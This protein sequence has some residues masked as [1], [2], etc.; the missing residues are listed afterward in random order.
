[1]RIFAVLRPDDTVAIDVRPDDSAPNLPYVENP[2]V[3]EGHEIIGIE[4][5]ALVTQEIDTLAVERSAM[6]CSPVQMRLACLGA[7]MLAEVDAAAAADPAAAVVWEY[8]TQIYRNSGFIAA[9]AAGFTN[10]NTA[11]MI[12]ATEIDDLFRAAMAIDP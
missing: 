8:A 7:G 6:I 4:N 5:G 1:M 11:Q 10:P 9:L 2:G 3:P 12:T